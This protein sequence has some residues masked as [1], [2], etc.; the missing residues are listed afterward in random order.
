M[1]V[2][3][4]GR[5]PAVVV[6]TCCSSVVSR[7]VVMLPT[8]A[9]PPTPSPSPLPKRSESCDLGAGT[10][11]GTDAPGSAGETEASLVRGTGGKLVIG[12]LQIEFTF[13]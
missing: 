10:V 2:L 13:L 3:F 9:A 5:Q 8:V 7:L 12:L 1:P 6:G 11:R 4:M